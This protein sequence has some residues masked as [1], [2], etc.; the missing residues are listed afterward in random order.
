M[1]TN[2]KLLNR[3]QKLEAQNK[4]LIAENRQLRLEVSQAN[5]V[6]DITKKAYCNYMQGID[7]LK[8][9]KGN[10]KN[11]IKE[12]KKEK[13][14]I[15]DTFREYLRKLRIDAEFNTLAEQS[16]SNQKEK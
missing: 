7:D 5:A 8:I 13:K 12:V 10:Y 11:A 15:R 3:I 14:K 2:K 16:E 4:K 1:D 9:L 6:F